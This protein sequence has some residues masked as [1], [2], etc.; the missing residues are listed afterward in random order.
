MKRNIRSASLSLALF[1]ASHLPHYGTVI[2]FIA[3]FECRAFAPGDNQSIAPKM[4]G[5]KGRKRAKVKKKLSRKIL[6]NFLLIDK[7][8][9]EQIMPWRA[10][11]L[12]LQTQCTMYHVFKYKFLLVTTSSVLKKVRTL[13]QNLRSLGSFLQMTSRRHL[14]D[15]DEP[16]HMTCSYF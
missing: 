8:R 3:L 11:G 2:K 14:Q 5:A 7:K 9:R 12:F 6:D 10:T 13:Y 1:S 15:T 16:N 4:A